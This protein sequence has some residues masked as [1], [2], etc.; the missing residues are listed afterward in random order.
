MKEVWRIMFGVAGGLAI[1]DVAK[2][3]TFWLISKV[4]TV[5]Y[6]PIYWYW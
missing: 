6:P 5:L 4:W 1:Y 2:S 3:L